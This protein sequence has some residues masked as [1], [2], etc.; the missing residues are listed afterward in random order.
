LRLRLP[1]QSETAEQQFSRKAAEAPRGR[2]GSRRSFVDRHRVARSL[3]RRPP[4]ADALAAVLAS[5]PM[6]QAL[7][8]ARDAYDAREWQRAH[9]SFAGLEADGVQLGAEDLERA[10]ICA[11]MLGE[12]VEA[13]E[14]AC[15]AYEAADR[16]HDAARIA[17]HLVEATLLIGQ[18]GRAQGWFRRA[19]RLL[20]H[21]EPGLGHGRLVLM[22][23]FLAV[24]TG[25]VEEAMRL[26]ERALALAR[27]HGDPDAE[28]L[29]LSRRAAL[30][31][32]L[33]E[34]EGAAG[35]VDEAMLLVHRDRTGPVAGAMIYCN[36]IDFCRDLGDYERAIEWSDAGAR[37]TSERDV[38]GFP[39]ICRVHRAELMRLRG[40]HDRAETELQGALELFE[41]HRF[42]FGIGYGLTELGQLHLERGALERAQRAFDGAEDAGHD[43]QPGAAALLIRRGDA[44]AAR[45]ALEQA[46]EDKATNPL[47]RARLLP[48]YVVACIE[49]GA[50]DDARRGLGELEALADRL[51]TVGVRAQAK[52]AAARVRLVEGRHRDAVRDAR[53]ATRAWRMIGACFELSE[54]RSVLARAYEASGDR[55]RAELER[56]RSGAE[57]AT[58][59]GAV[60]LPATDA[61]SSVREALPV[62]EG[63][64]IG[65]RIEVGPVLGIGGMGVVH[66]GVHR[67]TGRPVAVKVLKRT[68]CGDLVH[69]ERFL[70]E[71]RACGRIRH[72]NVVDVYDA[73]MHGLEPYIVMER[74]EG[75]SL[76]AVLE[77]RG[78]LAPDRVVDIAEQVA[79]GLAAAHAAE[80]IHRDLKPANVFVTT[81]GVVKVL[82]FG[83]SKQPEGVATRPDR[84]LG[85]PFYMAPEQIRRPSEVDARADVYA[86]G[87][88]MH[89]MLTGRAPFEAEDIAQVIY[90]ILDAGPPD[91][92]AAAPTA[93]EPLVAL[94]ES[95]MARDPE[96][97]PRDAAALA[98]ALAELRDG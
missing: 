83:I 58:S 92:R 80:V 88:V 63:V 32:R 38:S 73:G 9:E 57:L 81:D 75:R 23:G 21:A 72:A 8:T 56:S 91:L 84:L 53:A 74:L 82:D 40:D 10:G 20:E 97:R 35:D 89:E 71:A 94:V 45:E 7:R 12:P 36:T 43:P 4:D 19:G 61:P 66:S 3:V 64:V 17:L 27:E 50:L 96:D 47:G 86:L 34:I 90:L 76:E 95:A 55:A 98:D 2:D 31:M 30:R 79:R 11:W 28:A 65:D 52:T 46:L 1:A 67:V 48:T 59:V 37:W 49:D 25:K 22:E 15:E 87:I 68:V 26:V 42:G 77:E 78:P 13:L 39:G 62:R 51:G 5:S 54:A 69:C 14:R 60:T 6:D 85:T 44:R 93:P 29:A 24:F 16:L 33:G 41:R 70:Q 18:T